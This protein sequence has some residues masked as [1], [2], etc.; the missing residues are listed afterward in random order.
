MTAAMLPFYRLAG[1]GVLF[2]GLSLA[3]AFVSLQAGAE[4]AP[5][6]VTTDTA[7]YCQHLSDQVGQR[8]HAMQSPP[9]E[10]IRLSDEGE[11][12]C[13]EGQVRGGIMRLRRAWL[14]MAHPEALQSGR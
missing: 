2:A 14:L 4:S 5:M 10:V 3:I 11:R 8:V 12:L 6:E 1:T 7:V 9:P 13:D